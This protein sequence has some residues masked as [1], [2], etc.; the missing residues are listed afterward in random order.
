MLDSMPEV[1]HSFVVGLPHPVRG[2]VVRAAVVPAHGA[3]L[4]VETIVAHARRNL[5]TFKVPTIIHLLAEADLPMLDHRQSRPPGAG[6]VVVD[7]LTHCRCCAS[8]GWCS[9]NSGG[10]AVLIDA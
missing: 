3:P 6:Q 1:L 7:E 10:R 2:Q 8:G 4:S 5:S 9:P